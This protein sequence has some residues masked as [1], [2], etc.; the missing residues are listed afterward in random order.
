MKG[1][2]LTQLYYKYIISIHFT[3]ELLSGIETSQFIEK[4]L[5]L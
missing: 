2:L 5:D 1:Q 3:S 4:F